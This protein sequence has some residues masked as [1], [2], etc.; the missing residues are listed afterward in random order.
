MPFSLS[1]LTSGLKDGL[2]DKLKKIKDAVSIKKKADAAISWFKNNIKNL[3]GMNPTATRQQGIQSSVKLSSVE[4]GNMY[5]FVYDAKWKAVLPYWDKFPLSIVVEK[6]P[7]GFLGLN[8]HYLSPPM[9]AVLLDQLIAYR[10]TK[11][12][13]E[14]TRLQL[15]WAMLAKSSKHP[16][17]YPCVKRYLYTHVQSNFLLVTPIEWE[18]VIFLPIENFQKQTKEYVWGQSGF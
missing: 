8:L 15:S 1:K 9:R 12:I 10:T 13:T 3:L 14:K 4:I 18:H 6:Y 17:I 7:D 11:D 16:M 5:Q 2:L